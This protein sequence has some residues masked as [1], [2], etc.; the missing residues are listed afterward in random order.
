MDGFVWPKNKE[1][2]VWTMI[3]S[4]HSNNCQKFF[5]GFAIKLSPGQMSRYGIFIHLNNQTRKYKWFKSGPNCLW[6]QT[7]KQKTD[8]GLFVSVVR[9]WAGFKPQTPRWPGSC[10]LPIQPDLNMLKHLIFAQQSSAFHVGFG[11]T[12]FY[13]E[14]LSHVW[15]WGEK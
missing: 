4:T 3:I 2:S 9:T 8:L 14:V 7:N 15:P 13:R 1:L 12:V 11:S 5:C 6:K 10:A